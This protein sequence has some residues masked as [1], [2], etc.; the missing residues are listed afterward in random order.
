MF[1]AAFLLL[2]I[3]VISASA[4]ATTDEAIA[5]DLYSVVKSSPLLWVIG[6]AAFSL[7]FS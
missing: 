7:G 3:R 2:M 1:G 4:S 5:I 6:V